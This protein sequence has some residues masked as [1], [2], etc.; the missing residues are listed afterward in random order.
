MAV[1]WPWDDRGF[2]KLNNKNNSFLR[3]ELAVRWPWDDRGLFELISGNILIQ[4]AKV[5]DVSRSN[6]RKMWNNIGKILWN[7][8][9]WNFRIENYWTVKI[10]RYPYG[11]LAYSAVICN[12]YILVEW[13]KK[14]WRNRWILDWD[15]Q[16][17]RARFC[18]ILIRFGLLS[19][20]VSQGNF[21]VIII[22]IYL[23]RLRTFSILLRCYI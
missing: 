21:R 18:E 7:L 22:I 5:S 16:K 12:V 8:R 13:A 9:Y 6:G 14:P 20:K 11:K 4:Y 2:G 1:G 15:L 17:Y 23:H 19:E 3:T 10:R